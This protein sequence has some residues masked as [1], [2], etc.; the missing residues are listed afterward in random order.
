M[1]GAKP[2]MSGILTFS[3]LITIME[4]SSKNKKLFKEVGRDALL[5]IDFLLTS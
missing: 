1:S 2:P 3:K 5:D 4:K